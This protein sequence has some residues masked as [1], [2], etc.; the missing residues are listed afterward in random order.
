MPLRENYR[1]EKKG[2]KGPFVAAYLFRYWH[3]LFTRAY[4]DISLPSSHFI[5]LDG[6]TVVT[7]GPSGIGL[8]CVFAFAVE[9]VWV[10]LV[11]DID[12]D[13]AQAAS[14]RSRSIVTNPS[15]ETVAFRLDV[16]SEQSVDELM[17]LA[18]KSYGRIDLPCELRWCKLAN[19]MM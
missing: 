17:D 4:V 6:I 5:M 9:G 19:V 16:S 7:G 12:H 15:Y 18:V 13:R 11:A 1:D 10:V 14:K 3:F 8:D 2:I